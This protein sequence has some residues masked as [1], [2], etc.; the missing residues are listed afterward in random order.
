MARTKTSPTARPSTPVKDPWD[1]EHEDFLQRYP[2]GIA[3]S[4]DIYTGVVHKGF[5]ADTTAEE[6]IRRY[7]AFE[8]EKEHRKF[9][10]SKIRERLG[11]CIW[12]D[13]DGYYTPQELWEEDDR[14][15]EKKSFTRDD[16][17]SS[18]DETDESDE[19]D[20]SDD[21]DDS[22]DDDDDLEL[23]KAQKVELEQPVLSRPVPKGLLVGEEELES[24][25]ELAQLCGESASS[26]HAET[27]NS[28]LSPRQDT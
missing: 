28:S 17:G 8:E 23:N 5:D 15:N 1:R 20:E 22:D 12:R 16:D 26:D 21:S 27:T 2:Y 14:I 4:E 3:G 9:L 11:I 10:L 19:S 24:N 7:P 6:L 18:A 25:E 13:R